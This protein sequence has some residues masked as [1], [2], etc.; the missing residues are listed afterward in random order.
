MRQLLQQGG[1][2]F[3]TFLVVRKIS[4][5]LI[6]G[7]VLSILSLWLFVG[8]AED[9]LEGD[10]IVDVDAAFATELHREATPFN[11]SVYILISSLGAQGIVA[12][13]VVVGLYY[14]L[15]RQ[16][17]NLIFWIIALGGGI[18]LNILIKTVIARPRPYFV[19]PLALERSYSFPSAHSMTSLI[20]YGMLAYFLVVSVRNRYVRIVIVFVA[21][22]FIIL[23]GISRMALGVHYFS[24]V[25]GGF[26][27]G[28]MWLGICI[29]AANIMKP[30]NT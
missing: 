16:W 24:D 3:K 10:P 21:A 7:L 19:D 27:A 23:I 20:T 17:L 14:A 9:I 12:V 25:L 2:R 11:T 18:L 15:R 5:F 6:F 13:A 26:A 8:V 22:L 4:V 1:M 29:V 30:R 28:G